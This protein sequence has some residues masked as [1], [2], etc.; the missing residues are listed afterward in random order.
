MRAVAAGAADRTRQRFRT[1]GVLPTRPS[2]HTTR[3]SPGPSTSPAWGP[4]DG[5]TETSNRRPWRRGEES[6]APDR[7]GRTEPHHLRA[8]RR[9]RRPGPP[10]GAAGLLRARPE[11]AAARRL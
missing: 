5:G 7:D 3:T 8:L 2:S 6:R 1:A 4:A 11:G 10:D 9:H